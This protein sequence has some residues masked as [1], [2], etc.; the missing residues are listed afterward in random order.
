MNTQI[1]WFSGTGNTR[2]MAD[3]LA[4]ELE[5]PPVA[6]QPMLAPS[7]DAQSV[8]EA[9]CLVLAFPVYAFGAPK[10][11]AEFAKAVAPLPGT[12]VYTVATYAGMAGT[13]HAEIAALIADKEVSHHGG[14]TIKMPEN[15]PV[16]RPPPTAEKQQRLFDA[17]GERIP[18]IARTIGAG[19]AG[20]TEDS[21]VPIAWVAPSVHRAA[22]ARFPA[23]DGKFNVQEQ[24]TSCGVCEKVC[25]VG[26]ICLEDGQPTWHHRCEQCFAC[27]QW[28]PVA[29]IQWG[30]RTQDKPRYHHP[31][32]TASDFFLRSE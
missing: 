13:P 26:N 20:P 25:P 2:A 4:R 1:R 27:V 9:D 10:A 7:D 22:L 17:A 28:C 18:E 24:C 8:K 21:R 3:R 15:Y 11:V 6:V 14:W 5:L 19:E 29:A 30:R 12:L 16:M 31:G 32:Y 23:W